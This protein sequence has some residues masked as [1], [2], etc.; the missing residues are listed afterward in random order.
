MNQADTISPYINNAIATP[1]SSIDALLPQVADSLRTDSLAT[2]QLVNEVSRHDGISLPFSLEQI[3]GISVLLFLCFIS[4]C[5]IY[6]G[7]YSYLKES[8]S[9]LF[10]TKKSQRIQLTT[11]EHV[12]N[13]YLVF[14]TVILLSISMYAVFRGISIEQITSESPIIKIVGFCMA[15]GAFYI[16]KDLIYKFIGYIFDA[17]K[18]V[19]IWRRMHMLGVEVLG[20]LFFIPILLLVYSHAYHHQIIVFMLIIF[21]LV[22]ILLFYQ[23]IIFFFKQRFNFLYLIAYLCT[24]EILPYI[25]L[26]GGLEKLYRFDVFSI[27]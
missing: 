9:L 8:F 17:S 13:Y 10:S 12:Y 7:G 15:I 5:Y 6:N 25:F 4:F 3:D 26:F 27:L 18:S 23:I 2:E 19:I 16:L 11:T 21:L 20:I 24:F 1:W 14:Q 22:Q